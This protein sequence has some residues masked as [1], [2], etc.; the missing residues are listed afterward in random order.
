[1]NDF[2]SRLKCLSGPRKGK[3][4]KAASIGAADSLEQSNRWND[5]KTDA[6]AFYDSPEGKAQSKEVDECWA[7]NGTDGFWIDGVGRV[8]EGDDWE[9]LVTPFDKRGRE[10]KVGDIL[11][12]AMRN[13]TVS[14][15]L[16]EKIGEVSGGQ[17]TLHGT[18]LHTHKK[19]KNSYP[20]RCLKVSP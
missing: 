13:L 7:R 5:K 15:L 16:V 10:I 9:D 8:V 11:A 14:E 18:D 1:M 3:I 6:Y 12:Y 17:R 20:D 2:T 4:F 19:T